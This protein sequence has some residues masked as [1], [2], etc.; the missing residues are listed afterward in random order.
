VMPL[1]ASFAAVFLGQLDPAALNLIDCA[2]MGSIRSN[3]FHVFFYL[4]HRRLLGS[5]EKRIARSPWQS[6]SY[7]T[8]D[9]LAAISDLFTA[10]FTAAFERPVFFAS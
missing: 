7:S 5:C 9:P 4:S 10:F 6:T 1:M 8:F 3:N 2:D